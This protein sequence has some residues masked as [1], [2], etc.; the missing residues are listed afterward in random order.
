MD[1]RRIESIKRTRERTRQKEEEV[2][3]QPLLTTHAPQHMYV[4]MYGCVSMYVSHIRTSSMAADNKTFPAIKKCSTTRA[5]NNLPNV[6]SSK[7]RSAEGTRGP[8][9]CET[10]VIKR[11]LVS[12]ATAPVNSSAAYHPP[13]FLTMRGTG[14]RATCTDVC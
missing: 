10:C 1:G 3:R 12:T 6:E 9:S 13:M 5:S 14:R 8:I 7:N 4:C 11:Q 2:Q